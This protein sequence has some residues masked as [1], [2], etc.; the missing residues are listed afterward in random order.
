[1]T[2][3]QRGRAHC[4]IKNVLIQYKWTKNWLS[5]AKLCKSKLQ[6]NAANIKVIIN[7]KWAKYYAHFSS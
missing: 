7:T 5:L 2:F 6:G 4:N 1:M 3:L